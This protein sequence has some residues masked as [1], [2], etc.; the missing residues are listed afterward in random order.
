VDHGVVL[1]FCCFAMPSRGGRDCLLLKGLK[2]AYSSQNLKG[3]AGVPPN[4][5]VGPKRWPVTINAAVSLINA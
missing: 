3:V 1:I 4:C 2:M 5:T